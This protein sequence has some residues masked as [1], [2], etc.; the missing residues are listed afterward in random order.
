[1]I[2]SRDRDRRLCWRAALLQRL[3][4]LATIAVVGNVTGQPVSMPR[5][6][7]LRAAHALLCVLR[8]RRR[9]A[10]D[11]CSTGAAAARR[12]PARPAD[13]AGAGV[14]G[15]AVFELHARDA[16]LWPPRR[17]NAYSS[18]V[19]ELARAEGQF[20]L[21][22]RLEAEFALT[23]DER[24][25]MRRGRNAAG[26][27]RSASARKSTAAPPR[28]SACS[29]TCRSEQ[30]ARLA[31]VLDFRGERP[32]RLL[33]QSRSGRATGPEDGAVEKL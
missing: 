16:L 10:N 20:E 17:M 12:L 28:S 5:A 4:A 32:S 15:D 26:R 2:A 30:P 33:M 25:W 6:W 11:D 18:E 31:E 27:E 29:A 9:R 8:S 14:R 1:M 22:Q 19:L 3:S 23:D 7:L 24:E 13:A 21:L